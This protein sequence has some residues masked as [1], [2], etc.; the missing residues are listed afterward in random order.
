LALGAVDFVAK[1]SDL[2]S[3]MQE[4]TRELVAKIKVAAI[5]KRVQA[6]PQTQAPIKKST[7]LSNRPAT[8][9]VA[10]GIS[11]GGPNAIEFVLSQL[12][13]DYPHAIVIVQHM[14]EGFTNLFARRLDD[15]CALHVQE[16][17]SGDL[18]MAGRA[19]ICPGNRHIRVKRL[20]LGDVVILCD[21]ER[22]NGHRPSVEILF[23]SMAR[24]FKAQAITVLMTGMGED[25]AEAMGAVKAVG[26]LTIAQSEESCVVYGMP[27]AAVERGF[28]MR[29]LG[30]QEIAQAL[31]S[32]SEPEWG[33]AAA[34][35]SGGSALPK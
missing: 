14:P 33:R 19:L 32:L 29:V 12:P 31:Q 28:A 35:P 21:E 8:R 30:L 24:E 20:A 17:Q 6:I 34:A 13:S 9:V 27:K 4:V 26:G 18:L 5:S 16:A 7:V 11:T 25:G 3:H 15:S 1:P 10:I 23:Q 22:V 2:S